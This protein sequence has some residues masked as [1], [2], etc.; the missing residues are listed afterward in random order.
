M[1]KTTRPWDADSLANSE[2]DA[3]RRKVRKGTQSCWECKR[4]KVRCVVGVP[5]DPVCA[6]CRRRG[7]ACVGQEFDDEP[8]SATLEDRLGRVEALVERLSGR[9]SDDG[10][11]SVNDS[12]FLDDSLARAESPR[13]TGVE[14]PAD[15]A[16]ASRS[17]S[18]VT[19]LFRSS[20]C[21]P[22][23]GENALSLDDVL[24]LPPPPAECTPT[25][26]AKKLLL[27]ASFLLAVRSCRAK[28]F[29][30]RNVAYR[31]ALMHRAAETARSLVTTN[32]ALVGSLEGIECLLLESFYHNNLGNLRRAWLVTRR[33]ISFAQLLGLSRGAVQSTG[34]EQRAGLKPA[35]I[36]LRLVQMDHYL[37]LILS[38][39]L[40]SELPF[41][42]NGSD[43]ESYAGMERESPLSLDER[44]QRIQCEAAGRI[45][46][47]RNLN[48]EKALVETNEID[49]LLQSASSLMPG[50]W[51]ALPMDEDEDEDDLIPDFDASRNTLIMTQHHL[52][53]Q[54]YLPYLL[55]QSTDPLV[56]SGK[57]TAVCSSRELL[58]RY[59]LF[60]KF[61]TTMPYCRGID[62]LVFIASATLCISHIEA[63]RRCRAGQGGDA[64]L[65]LLSKHQRVHDRGLMENV[66]RRMESM[67]WERRDAIATRISRVLRPL[68]DLELD[69][70][71]GKPYRTQSSQE[72]GPDVGGSVEGDNVLQLNIPHCGTIRIE[73]CG[74]S[75]DA[76]TAAVK[77]YESLDRST[78]DSR[79][80]PIPP[81]NQNG[82]QPANA[83]STDA[84]AASPRREE[85]TLISG[86]APSVDD[87][88]LQGVDKA[89][90][91]TL[92]GFDLGESPRENNVSHGYDTDLLC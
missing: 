66:L 15:M 18:S 24:G 86:L 29:R 2:P 5:P 67:A 27:L 30:G 23:T 87:W 69:A 17:A 78:T 48:D 25:L 85:G 38:L 62:F 20:T 55:M 12:S 41:H 36:W 71:C 52:L 60:R 76:P 90:F 31:D 7:T 91:D 75:K 8:A 54:L 53:V 74:V 42:P 43:E 59:V 46:R 51:W 4:R 22:Y 13:P 80:P 50:K 33:A 61:T 9:D 45:I 40:G 92:L 3:K 77:E 6:G 37:S 14:V 82:Q 89:F 1:D 68:L 49:Y 79:A 88:A 26:L 28:A 83:G 56:T 39:P 58:S 47:R 21:T 81:N 32:D 65:T 73:P 16:L 63:H 72:Q 84:A 64:S 34:D 11:M 10:G 44:L 70:A 57:I 19:R 35:Y